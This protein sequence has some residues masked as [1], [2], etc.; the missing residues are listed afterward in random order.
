MI[1]VFVKWM[2]N[3]TAQAMYIHICGLRKKSKIK[4]ESRVYNLRCPEDEKSK[5]KCEVLSQQSADT[6]QE[7]HASL[8]T[9]HIPI[10]ENT[11]L[12][13]LVMAPS[14]KCRHKDLKPGT[15]ACSCAPSHPERCSHAPG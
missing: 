10:T 5:S 11:L 4:R 7:W 14:V 15:V 13:A 1:L 3:S 9:F 12:Q 8:N 6:E 2:D